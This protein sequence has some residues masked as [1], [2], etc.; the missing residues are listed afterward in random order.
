MIQ[1]AKN[2][3]ISIER[4]HVDK[5][6][7]GAKKVELRNRRMNLSKGDSVWVYS[8]KPHGCVA[9]K[10]T[11]KEVTEGSP[12]SLWRKFKNVCGISKEEFFAYYDG[13]KVGYAISLF[14]VRQL[15]A[16]PTLETIRSQYKKFHP[17]QFSK[18]LD[19]VPLLSFLESYLTEA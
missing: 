17:P 16:P 12:E 9:M 2:I 3:L 15:L 14:K 6:I 8:K 19:G 18:Y 13:V 10:A 1:P 4:R 11:V 7:S 5:I